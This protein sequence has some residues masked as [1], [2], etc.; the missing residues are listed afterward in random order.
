MMPRKASKKTKQKHYSEHESPALIWS[1]CQWMMQVAHMYMYSLAGE[2][3]IFS[4]FN[5]NLLFPPFHHVLCVSSSS[6]YFP[7]FLF[8]SFF[9]S[10]AVLF[11]PLSLPPS[12]CFSLSLFLITISFQRSSLSFSL[13]SRWKVLQKNK[14]QE[15]KF[16]KSAKSDHT[17]VREILGLEKT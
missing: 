6:F 14:K 15:K 16:T 17:V 1:L 7:C 5:W 2:S 9:F 8:C 3:E 12:L 10:S 4:S 11:R 13:A